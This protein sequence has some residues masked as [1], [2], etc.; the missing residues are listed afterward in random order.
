MPILI[1]AHG[2][3]PLPS[4]RYRVKLVGIEQTET[5]YGDVLKW[6]FIVLGEPHTVVGY[7]PVSG[8]IGSK[9]MRWVSALLNRPIAP[10]EQLDLETLLGRTAIAGIFYRKRNGEEYNEV[11]ELIPDN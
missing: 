4:G 5:D 8:S 11:A 1:T 10:N 7:T 6:V 3:E 9:C 2:N